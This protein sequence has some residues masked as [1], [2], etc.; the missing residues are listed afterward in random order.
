MRPGGVMLRFF[1]GHKK[2]SSGDS[3]EAPSLGDTPEHKTT[4]GEAD[5]DEGYFEVMGQ[6]QEAI[7]KRDYTRAADLARKNMRQVSAFVSGWKRESGK[8]DIASIPALEHGGTMLALAGDTDGLR[9][10]RSLVT[11]TRELAPWI[12]V[13]DQHDEDLLLFAAVLH[14]VAAQPGCLQTSI[15]TLVGAADGRRLGT[16]ISWLEKAGK[17]R[18]AK[19]GSTYSLTIPDPAN[20][21]TLS[22]RPRVSSHRAGRTP[23]RCSEINLSNLPYTP[24][25]R[26]PLRWEEKAGHSPVAEEPAD[27]EFAIRESDGWELT[28][29]EKLRPEDR[30]DPAFRQLH[31]VD[32]GV[33]LIDD[34]GKSAL[35]AGAPAAA[36]RY[37]RT[38]AVAAQATLLHDVYRIGA[39]ALG[40]GLIAMSSGCVAHAYNGALNPILETSLADS[41][42]VCAL[43]GRLEIPT[44]KLKNHLRCVGIAFDGTRYLFTGVDEA[45]CMDMEGRCLWGVRLPQTEG[46]TR[47]AQPSRIYGTSVEVQHA[48]NVMNLA[49]PVSREDFKRRYRELIKQWHPDLNPGNPVAVHRMTE[50]NL[51]AEILTG[52][53][54]NAVPRYAG[55]SYVKEFGRSEIEAGEAKLT[56]TMGIYAGA[57][58]AADWIYA[59][60]FG[61]R[62]HG[63]FLAGYS[64][65]IVQV[66]EDGEPVRAYDIGA[67]P[68]RIVDTGDYLYF[69]TDT[70]HYTLRG[71]TLVAV[72]D[73]PETGELLVAQT[74]FGL[75]EPKRFRWFHEDAV[76]L[77]TVVT[78]DPIRRV[79]YSPLGMIVETRTSRAVIGGVDTWW[80]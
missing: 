14:A 46:W 1:R 59:A 80:E 70:R 62:N 50:I 27:K 43:Q 75:L 19:S 60:N 57:L 45:W 24:L 28:S 52:L 35:C 69:L 67:V 63:A 25:P 21:Q 30:P 5:G 29:V 64:G 51:A 61:G 10:M 7:S 20:T 78:R 72:T 17:I 3:K 22:L 37:S 73:M 16:L 26:A 66:A 44:D 68:R 79:Y 42:E 2:D 55:V 65:R 13:V 11:A 12:S 8:F 74:G 23:G 56:I 54:Q 53:Q 31:P 34:L 38:G 36:L 39:N 41:P 15:R 4:S 33:I 32:T 47:I 48:L 58:Q 40:S 18:R 9:Q 49:L 76:H 6:L 77:G 71:D